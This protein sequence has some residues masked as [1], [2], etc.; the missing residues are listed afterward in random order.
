[1]KPTFFPSPLYK[2]RG[3]GSREAGHKQEFGFASLREGVPLP[4]A[5]AGPPYEERPG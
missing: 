1:M 5:F 4:L 3:A 2:G